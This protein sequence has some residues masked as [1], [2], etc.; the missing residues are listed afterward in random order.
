MDTL[1]A[2]DAA[3]HR[4]GEL[5]DRLHAE[6]TTC[7]RLFHGATEGVPGLAVDRYGPVLLVQTW[8]EPVSNDLLANISRRY[9]SVVPPGSSL[10]YNHRGS[11]GPFSSRFETTVTEAEG[12]ELGVRY[13]VRPRHRGQDPLLFLDFRAARRR[14]LERS[15]GRSVLNLFAYTCGIGVAAAR[16]GAA[17]AVNVDFARSALDVGEDNAA[18]N[19]LTSRMTFLH[20]DCLPVSRSFAGLPVKVRR[21]RRMPHFPRVEPRRFDL[22]VLDPPRWAK[23]AFGAVDVVRDY[24]SLFK[25][26]LLATA[27]GGHLLVTNHV[28]SVD[29]DD[30]LD[31]L[32]RSARKAERPVA[33]IEVIEPEGDFPSPDGRPPLKMAWVTLH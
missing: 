23:S 20:G 17:E 27:E 15:E 5:L 30:W 3:L 29:L 31:V 12:T 22:V 4:R 2:M 11:K 28:P 33:E 16:G 10:V 24:P 9:E 8:R 6:D 26:A 7:Y 18:L 1:D 25:P 13:D 32:R 19:G 21:G 14:M